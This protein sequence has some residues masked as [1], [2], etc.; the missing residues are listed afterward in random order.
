MSTLYLPSLGL[1]IASIGFIANTA[2]YYLMRKEKSLQTQ[3]D[4]LGCLNAG[5]ALM[6][7]LI[8]FWWLAWVS[9]HGRGF[10]KEI[11]IVSNGLYIFYLLTVLGMTFDRLVEITAP[12]QYKAMPVE[13]VHRLFALSS[14]TVAL[15]MIFVFSIGYKQAE[16][17]AYFTVSLDGLSIIINVVS[18]CYIRK[19]WNKRMDLA[20][21]I[22]AIHRALQRIDTK[23]I[24]IGFFVA[25]CA[26]LNAI[27]DVYI[28]I[29]ELHMPARITK[30]SSGLIVLFV[31]CLYVLQPLYCIAT[32]VDLTA[33]DLKQ[34]IVMRKRRRSVFQ[35]SAVKS[36]WANL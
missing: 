23:I 30:N 7:I 36:K 14:L 6:C 27:G 21:K 35:S 8:S 24:K 20:R 32:G 5:R 9:Y 22:G 33:T 18:Y 12:L 16:I 19:K 2:A 10:E 17:Q 31:S 28:T 1:L 25:L 3:R 13:Y 29:I 11:D 15:L 4:L 34:A 26:T